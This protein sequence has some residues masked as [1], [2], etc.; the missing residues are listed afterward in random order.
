MAIASLKSKIV[1]IDHEIALRCADENSDKIMK[2]TK[3]I[4]NGDGD[5][6]RL[7]CGS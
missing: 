1:K 6:A 7:T 5:V 2:H 3:E 4:S